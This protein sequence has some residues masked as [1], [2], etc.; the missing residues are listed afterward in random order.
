MRE[1]GEKIEVNFGITMPVN[2]CKNPECMQDFIVLNVKE[3]GDVWEQVG[4]GYGGLHCPYCTQK[5]GVK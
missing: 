1:H 2:V 4:N 3:N 5:V